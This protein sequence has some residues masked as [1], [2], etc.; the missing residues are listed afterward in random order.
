MLA[1]TMIFIFLAMATVISMAIK[2]LILM[3]YGNKQ[4]E[5]F[6]NQYK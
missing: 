5:I 2:E 3:A 6:V 1:L 4:E